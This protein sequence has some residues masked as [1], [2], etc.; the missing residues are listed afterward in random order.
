M[1][2]LISLM[3]ALGQA[4]WGRTETLVT[5]DAPPLPT[6]IPIL[7]LQHPSWFLRPGKLQY[8]AFDVF[9]QLL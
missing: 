7:C 4:L 5:N 9:K 3:P 6:E 2:F 1:S 8:N